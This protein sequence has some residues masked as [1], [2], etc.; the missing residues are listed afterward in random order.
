MNVR[1]LVVFFSLALALTW[2][3]WVPR[4]L[5]SHGIVRGAV[6]DLATALGLYWS[7]MPAIAALLTAALVGGRAE[8]RAWLGRLGR[9]RVGPQWYAI[10]LL[11]PAAFALLVGGIAA[12]LGLGDLWPR[13]LDSGVAAIGFF[14]VL[15]LTD[16]LGEET[17]WRGYALPALLERHW[18]LVASLILGVFWAVWHLPLWI[19]AGSALDGSPW[20]FHLVDLPA[21]SILYTWLFLRSRE[22][23]PVAIVLHASINLWVAAPTGTA[24]QLALVLGL[25]LALVAVAIATGLAPRSSHLTRT[26]SG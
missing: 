5:A 6:A 1:R 14:A 21:T 13:A 22:S 10:A 3:V 11:G 18:A 24:A 15:L 19:T 26:A 12:A 16:G 20:L 4:A 7:W 8:V 23:V 2:V 9:W 17:G 25:K